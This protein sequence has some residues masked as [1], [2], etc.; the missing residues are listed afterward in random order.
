MSNVV[1]VKKKTFGD[2]SEVISDSSKLS[3]NW[4]RKTIGMKLSTLV[5]EKSSRR[6]KIWQMFSQSRTLFSVQNL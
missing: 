6:P 3:L 2:G 4:E 5:M 1:M